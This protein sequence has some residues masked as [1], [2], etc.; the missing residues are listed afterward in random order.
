ME[1][2]EE[3]AAEKENTTSSSDEEVELTAEE[4]KALKGLLEE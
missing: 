1:K 3:A 4:I 2:K